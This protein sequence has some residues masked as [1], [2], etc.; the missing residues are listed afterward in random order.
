M[1]KALNSNQVSVATAGTT[2][3]VPANAN[4]LWLRITNLDGA[5]PV[6]LGGPG[7]SN[8]NGDKLASGQ[9]LVIETV[10]AQAAVYAQANTGAVTVGYSEVTA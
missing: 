9:S 4:R 7:V 3:V 6:F 5:N 8:L 1:S 10:A 2:L